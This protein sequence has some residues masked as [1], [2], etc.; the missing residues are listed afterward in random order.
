[1]KKGISLIVLVITIIVMIILAATVVITL[2]NTGIIE[3]ANEAVV[4]SDKKQVQQISDVIWAETYADKFRGEALKIE[5]ERRLKEQGINID[6]WNILITNS[7]IIMSDKVASVE[8]GLYETDSNY[9]ILKK[10]WQDLINEEIIHI[11][12]AGEI[13]T[14]MDMDTGE[15]SSSDILDGDLVLPNDGSIKSI[16][17]NIVSGTG[18]VGF[19]GCTKLTDVKLPD[20]LT[21]L[22]A[23]AFGFCTSLKRV[24]LSENITNVLGAFYGSGVDRIFVNPNNT[25]YYSVD[26]CLVDRA[27]KTIVL[28]SN[29]SKI[30]TDGSVV[31]IMDGAFFNCS[32]LESVFIPM[33][34][35]QIN[36]ETFKGCT[37][38]KTV[39]IGTNVTLIDDYAFDECMNITTVYYTGTEEQWNNINIQGYWTN[40]LK[41]A[42]KIYNYVITQ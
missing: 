29:N 18:N 3:R 32:K 10:T 30:P 27:T 23:Y 19:A 24:E 16:G 4:I 11:S 6:Y 5:V 35:K 37:G 41:S 20:S 7:G 17:Y 42:T 14:N 38:L 8:A 9:Q 12:E 33:T 13:Y 36:Y 25:V 2:T 34:M 39:T 26:D 31:D 1:M 28:G 21:E 22:G 40:S 15:N